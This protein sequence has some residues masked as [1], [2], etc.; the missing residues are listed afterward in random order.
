MKETLTSLF[1]ILVAALYGMHGGAESFFTVF[2]IGAIL[3]GA[4]KIGEKRH[5]QKMEVLE[6]IFDESVETNL[7][8]R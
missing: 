7:R 4:Y 1:I 6:K 3:Q 2:L 5:A 8:I